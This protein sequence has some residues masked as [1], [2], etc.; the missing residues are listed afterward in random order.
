[1][2][3]GSSST[4][5]SSS[6]LPSTTTRSARRP[7]SIVPTS[8][9]SP[10]HVA[11]HWVAARRACIGARPASTRYLSSSAFFGCPWPPAGHVMRVEGDRALAHVWRRAL[12]VV[13]VHRERGNEEGTLHGHL[14]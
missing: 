11:A 8:R 9:S 12:P 7:F 14:R 5:T 2:R 10:R 4:V 1:M 3:V 6:G 13:H